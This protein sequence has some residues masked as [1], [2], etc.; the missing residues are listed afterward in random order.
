MMRTKLTVVCF[1]GLF[2]ACAWT[3]P[4]QTIITT[5]AGTRNVPPSDG[6]AAVNAPVGYIGGV[7]ADS[8]GNI[9]FSDLA[10]DRV[11]RVD[12]DGVL[13]AFAGSGTA[14]YAGDDGPATS[15]A[16]LNPRGLAFDSAGN[17][18]IAD[19]GNSRIR[20][21]TPAGVIS[22][23]AGN[24][25]S[26]YAGDGGPAI[27]AALGQSLR[28]AVDRNSNVYISD[29]DNHRIRRVTTDGII[30]TFAGTG[31]KGSAGDGGPATQAMLNTPLGIAF[32]PAGNFCVADYGANR[33]RKV[34]N[35]NITTIAGTGTGAEAGDGGLATAA[36]LNGPAG[37]AVDLTGAVFIADQNGNRLRRIDPRTN[38]IST[39]AGTSQV[40]LG[41][42]GGPAASGSL[43][44]PQ[45]LAFNNNAQ[46]LLIADSAN[47]RVRA[48]ANGMLTTIAGNGNFRYAG[49]GGAGITAQ[50]PSPDGLALD[51]AGNVNICDSY[52]NRVRTA[53]IY[54]LI[55]LTAGTNTPGF[56]GDGGSAI[57]AKLVDCSGIAADSA[58]N[59]YVADTHNR[60]IRKIS[61]SGIIT[62]VAGNGVNDYAGDGGSALNAALSNPLGVAIDGSGNL[63]IADTGNDRIRKVAPAGLIISIAGNGTN[64]YAGDGGPASAAE[65]NAPSRI[66]VDTEGSIYFSDTGNNVVRR[67]STGGTIT[68]VAGNGQYG[69]AGD[70]SQAVAA[71]LANPQGLAVDAQGGVIIA[72][73]DNRRIRYVD[74]NGVIT[75]IAGNGSNT[76]SGDGRPPLS[77]GF[78]S[79]ADVAVDSAGNIY[80][81]DSADGRVRVIKPKPATLVVSQTGFTVTTAVDGGSVGPRTLTILNGGAGTIGWSLSTSVLSGNPAWLSVSPAQGTSSATAATPVSVAIN[82]AGLAA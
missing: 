77:T 34:V 22:T 51:T 43:Y 38:I 78:G 61:T 76:L 4:A 40:G 21:V 57:S 13:S 1:G 60:R 45:D 10:T 32:D 72:D 74:T 2:L 68:T 54:G 39:I 3:A 28:I 37:I 11:Y 20:K 18:Y 71:M 67:I 15:A 41:G 82:P 65:L 31:A 6:I 58:G 44:A 66:A 59:L 30:Q 47:F 70:G 24:G 16:L 81:A 75:T 64:G 33:V 55:Q 12:G 56:A 9:Y 49:D 63:Y 29:P 42:D 25:V 52:A 62:T 80:I 27:S 73:A 7:T 46:T 79:P 35:G 23:L 50:L 17:V 36:K 53:N 69:F 8:R 19:A 48:I 26:G 14:G 5:L